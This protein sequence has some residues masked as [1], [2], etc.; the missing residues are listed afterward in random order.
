MGLLQ[1]EF[2]APEVQ[3]RVTRLLYNLSGDGTPSKLALFKHGALNRLHT[4]VAHAVNDLPYLKPAVA[5]VLGFIA[6]KMALEFFDV[7]IS[8]Q[9]SLAVVVLLLGGGVLLSLVAP[10]KDARAKK[11][12]PAVGGLDNV[13]W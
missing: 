12:L 6:V 4:L 9:A 10:G 7:R 13:R 5:L 11:E 1:P 3:E 8:T 2:T